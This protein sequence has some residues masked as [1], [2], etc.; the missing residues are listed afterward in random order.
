[1]VGWSAVICDGDCA[2]LAG[3]E[4]G[5]T[6][7]IPNLA[8]NLSPFQMGII[9]YLATTQGPFNLDLSGMSD[10]VSLSSIQPTNSYGSY[11]DLSFCAAECAAPAPD[12]IR[13]LASQV[14]QRTA[15]LENG[16]V[17]VAFYGASIAAA[18]L[19]YT[20]PAAYR[21]AAAGIDAVVT[22]NPQAVAFAA[23]FVEGYSIGT[24]DE[25]GWP[26]GVGGWIGFGIGYYESLRDAF[27]W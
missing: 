9:N 24:A 23:H 27:H 7:N 3:S 16:K 15:S 2:P 10:F 22:G 25:V 6:S 21:V 13:E 12:P 26:D 1:V 11:Y 18:T 4:Q 8:P 17:I 19:T 20:G 5:A 14:Y